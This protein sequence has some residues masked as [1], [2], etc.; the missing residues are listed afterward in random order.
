[1]PLFKSKKSKE[2]A[3]D[4]KPQ[5]SGLAIA[6]NMKKKKKASGG[7]V[8]SGDPEMNYSKGGKVQSD[9]SGGQKRGPEGYP[10]YQE[11]AQ[12]QK[13]IHTP[14][15][16]VTQ[17][18]GGKGTSDAGSYT[19]ERYAGKPLFSGKDHPAIAEHKRVLKEMRETPDPILKAQGGE[20]TCP[21][22][23]NS[24][25]GEEQ[26]P[27]LEG[28]PAEDDLT[29]SGEQ[30]DSHDMDMIGRIMQ[31]RM[32]S[33]GGQVANTDLPVADFEPNEFDDLKLRD[34]LEFSD[35]AANSG[36]EDNDDIDAIKKKDVVSRAMVK[37]R[38]AKRD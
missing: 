24:F 4:S 15:S 21:H 2:D 36:D 7:T 34:G 16:G 14:V 33:K 11:Q 28:E 17:F 23:S 12:N 31:K 25:S 6:Y 10:K 18:P 35:T 37:K 22:C 20:I 30:S 9:F 19:K 26:G 32:M 8:E 38:A 27:V 29:D 13:G 5:K 1:M 3:S